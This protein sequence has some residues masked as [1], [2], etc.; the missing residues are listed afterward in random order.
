MIGRESMFK[1]D[2]AHYAK[3]HNWI[4]KHKPF[5]EKCEHCKKKGKVVYANISQEYKFEVDDWA[6][7]CKICHVVHDHRSSLGRKMIHYLWMTVL[8]FFT[9]NTELCRTYIKTQKADRDFQI[10]YDYIVEAGTYKSVGSRHGVTLERVR[11]IIAKQLLQ[12][13]RIERQAI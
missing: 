11:Q 3:V 7:L 1:K 6:L 12:L 8:R 5:I 9:K 4:K 10:L 2:P 13:S